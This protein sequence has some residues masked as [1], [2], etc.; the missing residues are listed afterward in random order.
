MA[1]IEVVKNV[2]GNNY[3]FEFVVKKAIDDNEPHPTMARER[4]SRGY[5][6]NKGNAARVLPITMKEIQNVPPYAKQGVIGRALYP[7]LLPL[8]PTNAGAICGF[9]V[10]KMKLNDIVD[11]VNNH[12]YID[13]EEDNELRIMEAMQ[14]SDV[15]LEK[16]MIIYGKMDVNHSNHYVWERDTSRSI[17]MFMEFSSDE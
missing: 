10:E 14:Y 9:L 3:A 7:F 15:A 1:I 16:S 8:Y 6:K 5:D 17:E 4:K 12:D 11:L 13:D 2:Y